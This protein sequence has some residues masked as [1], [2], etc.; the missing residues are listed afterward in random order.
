MSVDGVSE[1]KS[2][3][4][5]IDVYSLRFTTCRTIYPIQIIRPIGKHRVDQQKYLDIFLTDVCSNNCIIHSFVADNL[6]R[7]MA[8]ASKTHS[9]YFPCEYCLSKGKLLHEQDISVQR[10]KTVLQKQKDIVLN[11]LA[12]ANDI[13]DQEEIETLDTL[14]KG[15]NDAIKA[16]NKKNNNIVWPFST[17]DGSPR[18]RENVLEIT[19]KLENGEILSID[20]AK[21]ISGRSL[22]LDI[23]YFN[24]VLDVPPEYLH[25]VCI[26]TVKRTVELT[27]NVGESRQRN[28][29]RKLSSAAD[30][31]KLMSEVKVFRECSRRARNLD[32]AVLKGQEFRNIIIFFFVIVINC[33]EP[34]AVKER[35]IWLLQA[36][37]I[38]ICIIPSNEYENVDPGAL[39]YCGKH[40]YKLFEQLY[41][42]RNCSYNTHVVSSHLDKMRVHGPLT[43]TS[44]FG[45]ESFYGEM[46][47]CFTPGTNSP[48]KQIM[49]KVILKR[50][51]S[52]HYCQSSIYYSPKDTALES[53]SCVYTYQDNE[54]SFY[55]IDSI[56]GE[57]FHCF[58]L[59]KY[60]ATFIETPTLNWSKIGVF[61]AGGISDELVTIERESLAGKVIKVMN[62]FITCPINVLREK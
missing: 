3:I 27:F 47:H 5:S 16:L 62:Y 2:N 26:G 17:H 38:R 9:S 42:A 7:A 46:R 11:K 57:S 28:T 58:K 20:E 33:I 40:F 50:I 1:C 43:F 31:N 45:F 55:K 12:L 4:N 32:F 37:M 14:L 60:E 19:D 23:P 8:R 24:Y 10:R 59:G 49:E 44:A 6:K 34:S 30:F 13:N 25:S 15:I 18:T 61:E 21:G 29:T 51:L 36:Y 56:E 22:L 52:H 53:N 54:Y 39:L 41:H 35:R 48:A